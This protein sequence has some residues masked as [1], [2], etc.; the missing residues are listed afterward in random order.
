MTEHRTTQEAKLE[1][2][3]G[4]EMVSFEIQAPVNAIPTFAN[5]QGIK[6]F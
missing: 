4:T 3:I 2:C 6:F 1:N 5:V